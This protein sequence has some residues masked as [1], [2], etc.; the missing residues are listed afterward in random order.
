TAS[1]RN[2]IRRFGTSSK[3]WFVRPP[4]ELQRT[5]LTGSV[6]VTDRH[7]GNFRREVEEAM[8]TGSSGEQ[9]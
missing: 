1:P 9:A 3:I 8:D 6:N 4:G 5:G 7:R 2:C